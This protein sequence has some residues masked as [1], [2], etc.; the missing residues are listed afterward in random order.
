MKRILYKLR[1]VFITG[2]IILLPLII[3]IAVLYTF[4]KQL[5]SYFQPIISPLFGRR[6]PGLGF[7]LGLVVILGV[8][9]MAPLYI[10]KKMQSLLDATM[11]RVPLIKG[12]YALSKQIIDTVRFARKPGFRQVVLVEYPRKGVFMLGFLTTEE[13]F[14]F[15]DDEES[16]GPR[17][18]LKFVFIPTTPNP[19]SG[20]LI[21]VPER[22]II[23][24][25]MQPE[26]ALKVIVSGG[27]IFPKEPKE[28]DLTE[29]APPMVPIQR[30]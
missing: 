1:T 23:Y 21:A 17:G 5:D 7:I 29:K 6:I 10:G 2:L 19:T 27:L 28:E 30:V 18:K 25:N 12:I 13:E 26:D 11:M 20:F 9:M 8:G 15:Y 24:L 4:G 16:R 22:E 14:P 3:S